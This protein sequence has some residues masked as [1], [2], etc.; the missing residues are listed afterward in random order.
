MFF[1]FIVSSFYFVTTE[2][3][4]TSYH[5]KNYTKSM[6]TKHFRVKDEEAVLMQWKALLTNENGRE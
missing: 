2:R 1:V 6:N 5:A 4:D 3:L